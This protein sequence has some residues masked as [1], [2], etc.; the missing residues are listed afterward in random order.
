MKNVLRWLDKHFELTIMAILLGILTIVMNAEILL[1]FFHLGS[2]KWGI[3]FCQYTFVYT[4]FLALPYCIS[5]NT[6]LRIDVLVHALPE[7]VQRMFDVAG[8]VICLALWVFFFRH[9]L[10]VLRLSIEKPQYS[11]TLGISLAWLYGV[12]VVSFLLAIIRE[13]QSLL[14]S[15]KRYTREKDEHRSGEEG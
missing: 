1:R 4:T 6:N 3:E 13:V 7:K 15:L 10:E 2:L 8:S 9:S 12:P 5:Q 14:R 11:S